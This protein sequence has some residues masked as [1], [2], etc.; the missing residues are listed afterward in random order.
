MRKILYSTSA[1]IIL[2]L[3]FGYFVIKYW[4]LTS[5]VLWSIFIVIYSESKFSWK[6]FKNKK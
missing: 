3:T 1:S 6:K 5:V 4:S 2:Y